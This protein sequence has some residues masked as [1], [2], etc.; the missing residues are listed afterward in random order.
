MTKLKLLG[1][2]V[3]LSSVLAG[4]AM[5]QRAISYPGH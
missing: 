3:V 1:A 2:A 4:P 5:A